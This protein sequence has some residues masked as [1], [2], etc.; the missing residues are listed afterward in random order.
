MPGGKLWTKSEVGVDHYVANYT[1]IE[2]LRAFPRSVSIPYLTQQLESDTQAE[3]H[4]CP[5]V[6]AKEGEL[7]VFVLAEITGQPWHKILNLS[8]PPD[9]PQSA[10]RS[11]LADPDQRNKLKSGYLAYAQ[12]S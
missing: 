1:D 12:D 11:A 4:I 5:F 9:N 2:A 7:A 8:E 10:V 6:F 3:P